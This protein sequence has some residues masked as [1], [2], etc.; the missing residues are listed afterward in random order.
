MPTIHTGSELESVPPK[1]DWD[2]NGVTSHSTDINRT[3]GFESGTR[4][5]AATVDK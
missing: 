5:V 4:V 2:N 3:S 1:R